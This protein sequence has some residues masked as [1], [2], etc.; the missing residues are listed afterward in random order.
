MS[1][2][3]RRL[4]RRSVKNGTTATYKA[5]LEATERPIDYE[6]MGVFLRPTS[7]REELARLAK[8]RPVLPV[9]A[10]SL[11]EFSVDVQLPEGRAAQ[12]ETEPMVDS[13]SVERRFKVRVDARKLNPGLIEDYVDADSPHLRMDDARRASQSLVLKHE[14]WHPLIRGGVA[15]FANRAFREAVEGGGDSA[16]DAEELWSG[17][18]QSAGEYATDDFHRKVNDAQTDREER[19][20]ARYMRN[21]TKSPRGKSRQNTRFDEL[22]RRSFLKASVQNENASSPQKGE[23]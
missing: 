2:F 16:D 6:R 1:L 22:L 18:M 20:G 11:Q 3:E 13:Q 8:G 17:V 7:P 21:L 15:V 23:L 9:Q 14:N 4:L 19:Q 5:A 12:V 10:Q